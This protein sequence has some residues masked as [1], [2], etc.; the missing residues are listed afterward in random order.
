MQ[1][2]EVFPEPVYKNKIS[3][4]EDEMSYLT[5]FRS[6]GEYSNTYG[7]TTSND[8]SVLDSDRLISLRE[9]IQQHLDYYLK[10]IIGASGVSLVV[11]QSWINFNDNNTSHHTHIHTNSIVSGVFYV[12][13]KPAPIIMF[14]KHDDFMLRPNITSVNRYNSP[15]KTIV[16]EQGDVIL[17]PSQIPHGVQRNETNETR[18]SL[19]FNTFYK[20]SLG[21][22]NNLTYLEL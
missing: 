4:S 5:S 1:I 6:L 7:N 9:R 15:T 21:S 16:V 11:T 10:N 19:A 3:L 20:G 14:K 12:T 13:P 2:L 17:F 22:K 18:I 8:N